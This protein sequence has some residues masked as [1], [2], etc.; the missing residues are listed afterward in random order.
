MP[1]R[2][3]LLLADRA[4]IWNSRRENRQLPS[5]LHWLQIRCLTAKRD[6]TRPQL[7][8][9]AK[10]GRDH[11]LRALAAA[12]ALALLGWAGYQVH[13]TL[14]AHA[15]TARLLDANTDEVPTIVGDMA[16]Y[17]RWLDP[18]LY[19][20][21][22]Q[23]EASKDHRKRLRASLA[24]LPVD[25]TQIDY[26]YNRLL[27]AD[28]LD[29]PVIR[30]ALSPH[31]NLLRD[32]LWAEVESSP[33]D[34]RRQRLQAASALATYDAPNSGR[35]T[36][37]WRSAS[38]IVVDEMLA[39]VERNPS[40]FA[41][42][43]DQFRPVGSWLADPLAEVFRSKDRPDSD[44]AF[45]TSILADYAANNPQLL[46][47]LLMD[48]DLKQFP[49]LY[50]KLK[51]QGTSA[52]TILRDE[53]AKRRDSIVDAKE[54]EKLASR[55]ANAAAAIWRL[56]GSASVRR[57]LE[58]SQD[59]TVRSYLVRRLGPLGAVDPQQIMTLATAEP[60]V[61][62]RRA[63]VLSLGEFKD[64]PFPERDAL[65]DWL[66]AVYE[67]D[68]DPGLHAAAEYTLGALGEHKRID[69]IQKRL[70]ITE[71]QIQQR[72][73]IRSDNSPHWYVNGRG[74]TMVMIRGPVDFVMG[75]PAS[76][77]GRETG[78]TQHTVRIQRTFA[79]AAKAVTVDEFRRLQ[80]DE[81][82]SRIAGL[83]PQD[84]VTWVSWHDAAAHCNR[85]SLREGIS[86]DQ[87]CYEIDSNGVASPR[88][89]L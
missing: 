43:L 83:A 42:L 69:E 36:V 7:I 46:A 17:R 9:M 26:L 4:G 58:H 52:L 74:R 16:A 57:L 31:M 13:G 32:R 65:A 1:G 73:V 54:R 18:L 68:A 88:R 21:R 15:L 30:D 33:K 77:V 62:I 47:D 2:A 71:E 12:V 76:E 14:Q 22:V 39:A 50:P 89:T 55:Q 25:D 45:A 86:R 29:V 28:P 3:E 81:P 48:A 82:G 40:H 60:N 66:S 78:E 64:A 79:I 72:Y 61:S 38:K 59:P 27:D 35:G 11:A 49:L 80:P 20:A 5:L 44:R 75:S 37:R 10:A 56:D 84:P 41:T 53:L 67:S 70:C 24:L 34:K 85:L 19:D 51:E 23:A 6:W 87:W 63:L 8:M